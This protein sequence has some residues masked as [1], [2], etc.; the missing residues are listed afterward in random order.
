MDGG[1]GLL[2]GPGAVGGDALKL[3][4]FV[5]AGDGV[6][7]VPE[8][9]DTA[10]LGEI[11][12]VLAF[13]GGGVFGGVAGT[14]TAGNAVLVGGI[15]TV[16]GGQRMAA[17][18]AEGGVAESEAMADGDAL[19]K[20][21]AFAGETAFGFGDLFEVAQNAALEVEDFLEALAQ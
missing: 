9:I 17:G 2:L 7:G 13:G 6:G 5:G 18:A 20:D 1:L 19:I 12:L 15:G 14:M 3:F 10:R 11:D 4:G 8:V 21:E 16:F